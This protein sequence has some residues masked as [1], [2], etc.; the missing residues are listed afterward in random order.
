MSSLGLAADFH[1]DGVEAFGDQLGRP[2]AGPRQVVGPHRE[3]AA[4]GKRPAGSAEQVVDRLAGG[5]AQ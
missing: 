2:C 4:D 5:F 3:S 1:L